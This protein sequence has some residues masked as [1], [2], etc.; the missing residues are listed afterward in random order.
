[1]TV[2][3]LGW[4]YT[5]AS[6]ADTTGKTL[7]LPPGAPANPCGLVAKSYFT[8]TFQIYTGNN[9][10]DSDVKADAT[11]NVTIHDDGIAWDSD[12][13]YKFKR[14]PNQSD[15][16]TWEDHSWIDVTDGIFIYIN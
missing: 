4:S 15:G 5:V 10:K 2:D 9:T 11:K 12:I 16:T 14:M 7:G 13:E 1:M 6:K 3:E 8:D